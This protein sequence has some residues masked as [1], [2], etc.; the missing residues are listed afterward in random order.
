M[1]CFDLIRPSYHDSSF[2]H[3]LVNKIL[4]PE[5]LCVHTSNL[6]NQCLL[7][8]QL[9]FWQDAK[10]AQA[11]DSLTCSGTPEPALFLF[12]AT[13][14]FVQQI[15]ETALPLTYTCTVL[16]SHLGNCTSHSKN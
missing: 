12:M 7:N 10:L 14:L 15:T 5:V 13:V 6:S 3:C 9:V 8:G 1:S 16:N 2:R 4:P 11:S